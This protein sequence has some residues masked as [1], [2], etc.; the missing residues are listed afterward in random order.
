MGQVSAISLF[1][2]S[3]RDQ[4]ELIKRITV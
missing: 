2:S 3:A 1:A 4:L